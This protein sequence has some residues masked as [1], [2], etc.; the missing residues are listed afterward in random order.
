MIASREIFWNIQFGQ[1]T[2][3]IGLLAI[4]VLVYAIYRYYR[5]WRIGKPA[6]RV[7]NLG[8]RVWRFVVAAVVDGIIHRKF[9]GYWSTSLKDLTP[10]EL[11][12]G[13]SHFLIFGGSLVFLFGSFLDFISHYLFHFLEGTAYLVFSAVVDVFG[14]L[15]IFGVI[16]ALIRRYAI[17]PKRLDSRQEDI[18]ALMLILVIVA[19]GFVIEGMRISVTELAAHP[20]WAPWS[21]GGYALALLFRGVD[22]NTLLGWHVGVWWFHMLVAMGAI[23]YVS[24]SASKLLHIVWD[25]VNVFLKSFEPRGALKPIDF[26]AEDASFGVAKIEDFNW[27]QLLDLDACTRC[28]RCQDACPAHFSGKDLSPKQVIQNLK[29]H[30]HET[31]PVFPWQKPA[32]PRQDMISDVVTERVVWDCTTCRACQEACPVSIEHVDKII[33]M[34]RNLAMEQSK[35]PEPVQEALKSLGSRGHP[36]RGTSA[37]RTDWAKDLEVKEMGEDSHVELLY[38]VGCSAALEDRNQKVSQAMVKILKHLGI[39]FG[40][41][42]ME[43]TCC[44]DPARRLGDEYLY[45]TI[46][47]GNI[48]MLNKYGVK[49]ILTTCPHCYNTLKNEYP[50][51][52]GH[53]EV[54][55]HTEFIAD[56]IR[57]GKITPGNL[58]S[59][60]IAYHDSC[61][62]GR[63]NNIYEEP[64]EIISAIPGAHHVEL[65]RN[66]ANSFCCGG[67][68]GHMWMEEEPG[69]RV[70]ERRVAEIIQAKVNS[71]TTACPFCLSMLEDGL[72]ARGIEDTKALDIAELIAPLLGG[73]VVRR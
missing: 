61:Y 1:I 71:V 23:I 30:F 40:I 70:S 63:Y 20:G 50:Q 42:G 25:P 21:P 62:L 24:L 49:E 6:N 65:S 9:L 44:G 7:N 11:Y 51:F 60:K 13:L 56:L 16:M 69:K 37:T 4:G 38:W 57:Q 52:G 31:Y 66:K 55:H 28:G 17:K 19:S 29:T 47:Q 12:A 36:Y 15:V 22:Q 32:D 8:T 64:R 54:V 73:A 18:I 48:E 27:K 14:I 5:T 26:E 58:E 10:R 53:Y 67:G 3:F 45:Q 41:L 43:E 39:S 72:K 2:Y 33:D 68:G 59:Q 46:C 35:F 34:R